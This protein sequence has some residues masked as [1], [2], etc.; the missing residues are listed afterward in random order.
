MDDEMWRPLGVDTG[1][2]VAKYDALHDGIPPWMS[3]G[4]WAWVLERIT[5]H[6]RY[7]DG[8]GRVPMLNVDLAE[9]MCQTL[10]ITLPNLRVRGV[11]P[12]TGRDQLNKAMGALRAH[13]APLQVADFLLAHERNSSADDL[14]ALLER[15]KS[16]WQVGTRHGRPGLVRRVPLGVQVAADWVMGRAH[17]AGLRLA[18]AWEALYGLEPNASVAYGLAIKAVEDAAVPVVSPE[19]AK[20]T[21]GT[22]LADIEQQGDWQLPMERE[23]DRAPSR[24]VLIGMMRLLWHGQHDRHGGQPSA[25]GDVSPEEASVAVSLA[26][27]I[28]NLFSSGV[29][30]RSRVQDS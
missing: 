20:A 5:V 22:V 2:D 23:H 27:T 7:P 16:A 30:A 9:R 10:R 14:N 21:L 3:A 29:V 25:P 8:S 15:S 6:R 26:V 13:P 11:H 1:P 28:V 12:T 19:N 18:T 4:Y 17:R 24:E